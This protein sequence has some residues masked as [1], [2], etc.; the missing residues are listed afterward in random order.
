MWLE[1]INISE[2]P[3]YFIT[4]HKP[5]SKTRPW[6][7]NIFY[8]VKVKNLN[9]TPSSECVEIGFFNKNSIENINTIV[10][11]KEFFKGL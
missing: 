2:N 1:V 6:I 3:K 4:A 11:V 9:F 8:E 5:Q 10:N 7:S